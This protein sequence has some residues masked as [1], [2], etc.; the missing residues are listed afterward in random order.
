MK[1]MKKLL[2]CFAFSLIGYLG[3]SQVSF[4]IKSGINIATTKDLIAYPKNR[5]GWYAGGIVKIHLKKKIFLQ[6]EIIFSTQGDRSTNQVGLSNIALRLNYIKV[7]VL[8]CYKIDNRTFLFIGPELGYLAS[9]HLAHLG[10]EIINVS[11]NY[12]SKFDAGLD[13][14]LN[15]K[16]IKDLIIE[17]RYNYGFK[18]L[19]SV[20]DT[21]NRNSQINGANRVFQIGFSYIFHK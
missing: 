18:T 12:S 20:D 9:A 8:L 17:S 4:G 5:I 6:P 16:L 15:Y 11:K 3:Y 21:G 10:N 2:I 14:G 1:K 13:I 19:Y 7:P